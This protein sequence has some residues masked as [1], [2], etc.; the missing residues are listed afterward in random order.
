MKTR[1]LTRIQALVAGLVVALVGGGVF[2]LITDT[3]TSSGNNAE[4]GEFNP[5]DLE[6]AFV[7]DPDGVG[8]CQNLPDGD[9]ANSLTAWID[10]AVLEFGTHTDANPYFPTSFVCLRN[11]GEQ[12]GT[13]VMQFSNLVETEVGAC[14]QAE[15]DYEELVDGTATCNDGDAGELASAV[16]TH[17]YDCDNVFS[18]DTLGNR[19]SLSTPVG[20]IAAGGYCLIDLNLYLSQDDESRFMGQTDR[21]QWDIDFT[22]SDQP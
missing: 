3:V 7:V 2:A 22:L 12:D 10:G 6:A 5:L 18:D 17:F 9:Y 15:F 14:S 20:T 8:S 13:A 21:A 4:T 1:K 19:Q 16:G 11:V